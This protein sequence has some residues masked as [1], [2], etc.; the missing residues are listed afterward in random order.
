MAMLFIT[1]DLGIVRR[2]AQ[3]VCVM[4]GGRSSSRDRPRRSSTTRSTP[5]R[6]ICSPPSRRA[7]RRSRTPPRRWS[8]RPRTS[9]SGSRSSR[10]LL[11]RA[12]GYVKAVDGVDVTVRR[13]PDA[14]RRRRIRLRQDDARPGDDAA[15]LV[16][17]RH[18][19][20]RQAD[21]RREV[22]GDAAAP[23]ATCR[24]SSR[25][26]TARSAR[27]CRVGDIV[28]E[29]L[30][31]HARGLTASERDRRVAQALDEVGLDP[32][33]RAPLSARVLRRPAPAHRGGA[34]HGAA[35]RNS[36]CSTSRPRRST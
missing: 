31:I 8:W 27:A 10:G 32:A 4:T 5:I 36:S 2:M 6:G 7:I 33:T 9:R 22:Q 34:R 11:R 14:R 16:G 1:H 3:R 20:P 23:R 17:G 35:S 30:K 28:G 26:P 29:G 12:V 24:S 15:D 18:R 25:I 19:L 13:G 21:R